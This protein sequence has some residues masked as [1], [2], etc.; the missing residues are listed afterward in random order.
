MSEYDNTNGNSSNG[1]PPT[2][3]GS[4][5]KRRRP[6]VVETTTDFFELLELGTKALEQ[7][8]ISA[9]TQL[10]EQARKLEPDHPDLL[11][12]LG[13]AYILSKKF[14]QAVEVL[15]SLSDRQPSNPMVWTNLGAAYLGNPILATDEKQQRAIGA[16][17][18]AIALDPKAPNVAYNLGLIYRDRQE[19]DEA[20]HWFNRA[21]EANP[22]DK[23]ARNYIKQLS[24][25]DGDKP[26]E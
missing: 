7:G 13:G 16:F 15:E 19:N 6:K 22:N 5:K 21:L 1:T 10:L 20:I 25:P 3:N 23:D 18:I 8:Q 26:T 14:K 9:A 2:K 24:N 17:K 11:L 4:E 12:N